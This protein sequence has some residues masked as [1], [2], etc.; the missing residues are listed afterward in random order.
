MATFTKNAEILRKSINDTALSKRIESYVRRGSRPERRAMRAKADEEK[1]DVVTAILLYAGGKSSD[2]GQELSESQKDHVRRM[3]ASFLDSVY[4]SQLDAAYPAGTSVGNEATRRPSIAQDEAATKFAQLKLLLREE[5]KR[6]DREQA[7]AV[8]SGSLVPTLLKDLLELVFYDALRKVSHATDLSQHL[9]NLQAFLDDLIKV[10]KSGDN[11]IES[12][13]ALCARHE[14]S[15]YFLIHEIADVAGPMWE[16][17]QGGADY[18]SLG[19]VD[20]YHPADRKAG[21]LQVDLERLLQDPRLSDADV[22]S[23]I[24]ETD[25]LVQFTRWVKVR[26]ELEM[27]R[28]YLLNHP[29]AAPQSGLCADDIPTKE[30]KDRIQDVDGLMRE[31]MRKRGVNEDDGLVKNAQ[32][33]TEMGE[34]PMLHFSIPDPLRQHYVGDELSADDQRE[35]KYNPRLVTPT[36][37]SM[38]AT[39][40]LMAPLCESLRA[41]L[42]DWKQFDRPFRP[43]ARPP[44]LVGSL[45]RTGTIS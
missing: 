39:R 21:H 35:L 32:R 31:L 9:G 4:R 45:K 25:S 7:L 37:P 15:L 6:R 44:P 10:R 30:M 38:W 29:D 16:W 23:I 41:Q 18:M 17:T 34:Y 27:R 14:Q 40:K 36:Y 3:E 1:I 28:N 5:L 42:P 26:N 20:P 2:G 11:T 22:E 19:T 8:G 43:R 12:W 33:G 24:K 13:I